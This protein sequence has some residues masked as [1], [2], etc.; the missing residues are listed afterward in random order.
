[1]VAGPHCST[2]RL[3]VALVAVA[4]VVDTPQV[5]RLE[6]EPRPRQVAPSTTV[7]PDPRWDRRTVLRAA[8]A[9]LADLEAISRVNPVERAAR[10]CRTPLLAQL[11]STQ[12]EAVVAL[13]VI[14]L[15]SHQARPGRVG[16]VL[17]VRAVESTHQPIDMEMPRWLTPAPVAAARRMPHMAV[18]VV[19]EL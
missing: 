6:R 2:R 4:S 9:G 17:A 1:M 11:S 12:V 3:L 5:W 13:T 16:A 15:R 8:A 18:L 7:A 10:V 19:P 14:T